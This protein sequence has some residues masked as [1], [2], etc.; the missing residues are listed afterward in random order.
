M[1]EE[2]SEKQVQTAEKRGSKFS[3]KALAKKSFKKAKAG[4][5]VVEVSK[6]DDCSH[7]SESVKALLKENGVL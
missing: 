4:T 1:K 6:G 2:K 7:L 3:N 5:V